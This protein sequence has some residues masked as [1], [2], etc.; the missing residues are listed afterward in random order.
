MACLTSWAMR[1][2]APVND[3]DRNLDKAEAGQ[4]ILLTAFGQG[5]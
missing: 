1:G 2:G 3:V 4:W 5:F